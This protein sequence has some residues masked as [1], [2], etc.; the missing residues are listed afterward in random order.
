MI[1]NLALQSKDDEYL[2]DDEEKFIKLDPILDKDYKLDSVSDVT[3]LEKEA[4]AFVRRHND[5]I[6]LICNKL[7]TKYNAI[8]VQK[9][10]FDKNT[11]ET[12]QIA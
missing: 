2:P 1:I 3:L 12:T 6:D 7:N 11:Q 9:Y 10:W 4:E 8:N 5:N